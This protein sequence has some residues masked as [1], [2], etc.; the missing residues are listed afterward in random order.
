[1]FPNQ[2]LNYRIYLYDDH[3]TIILNGG[4]RGVELENIPLEVLNSSAINDVSEHIGCSLLVADAPPKEK[5]PFWVVFL[6]TKEEDGES[7]QSNADDRWTS[8]CRRARRRQHHNVIDSP[9]LH[10][11]STDFDRNL[12]IFLLYVVI[13]CLSLNNSYAYIIHHTAT[14]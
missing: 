10:Q 2:Y 5:P 1:M 7:N 12:S 9:R 14:L 6:L 13:S 3:Y 11:I 4:N 8:A